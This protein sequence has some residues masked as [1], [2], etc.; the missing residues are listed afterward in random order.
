MSVAGR[1]AAPASR[2]TD[3]RG[4]GSRIALAVLA[5]PGRRR[6]DALLHQQPSC[7]GACGVSSTP[8]LVDS[9]TDISGMLD[10]P[11]KPG[12]DDW[13]CCATSSIAFFRF[14]FQTANFE[15]VIASEAKHPSRRAKEEWIA[16][17]RSQ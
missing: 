10:R 9:I 4:Y 7:P 17:L 8:W 3:I 16:S 14:D 2:N 15:T 13:E 5:C 12:D 6:P 11:V 1:T